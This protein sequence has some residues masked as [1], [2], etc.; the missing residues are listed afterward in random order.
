MKMVRIGIIYTN[1]YY[2]G[3]PRN[4]FKHLI[5]IEY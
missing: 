5:L 1:M 2:V 4:E 3:I